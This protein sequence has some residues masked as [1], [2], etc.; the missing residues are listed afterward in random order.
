MPEFTAKE[1]AE[2]VGARLVGPPDVVITDV[3]EPRQAGP[4][5]LAF[6]RDREHLETAAG[7][8]AGI[9]LA[10]AEPE[11]FQGAVLLC[12]DPESA[13][14]RVLEEFAAARFPPPTGVSPRAAVSPD[15]ELAGTVAVGPGAFVGEGAV[16]E[17]GVVIHPG[18]CVGRRCR[19]GPR[20]VV[21]A[22]ASI[23]DGVTIGADCIIHYNAVVG[24]E[25]FGFLQRDG[26]NVK[27]PQVG[28]VRLGDGVELG[29][30]STIDRGTV[31]DTVVES[32]TK[33]DNH[34]HIAHN[35]HVGPDCIMAGGSK[36]AGSVRL[37][38]GV[39][40]AVD[41]GISDHVTVGDGAVL[42]AGTGVHSDVEAGAVLLGRPARPIGEQRR[43][44]ALTGRLPRLF[45]KLRKLE[46]RIKRL[47]QRRGEDTPPPAP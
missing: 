11:G 12:E 16:L 25:G 22:N 30:L 31:E 6:V 5:D 8:R 7:C 46:K 37:G 40:V 26:A 4:R 1:L 42:G 9:L 47:E 23:H 39:I 18:A 45:D 38:R 10:P 32:G 36:L 29:A 19:I 33:I 15:A 35:C 14:A 21:C 13:A 17:D 24:A 34:C 41:V 3:R 44:Y 27:V 28:S 20:T 2:L 43:I